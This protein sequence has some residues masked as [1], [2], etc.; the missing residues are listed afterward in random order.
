MATETQLP[1]IVQGDDWDYKITISKEGTGLD[2]TGDKFF[3][4][5]KLDKDVADVSAE[6]QHDETV[7]GGTD[8]DNG[9]HYISVPRTKTVTLEPATHNYDIQWWDSSADKLKTIALGEVTVQQQ[10]TIRES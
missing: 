9:I 6:L 5:L 1:P 2:I 8:A 10:V 4:T 3:F 7:A